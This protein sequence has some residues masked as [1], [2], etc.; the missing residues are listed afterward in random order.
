MKSGSLQAESRSSTWY[1][2][3]LANSSLNIKTYRRHFQTALLETQNLVTMLRN[4]HYWKLFFLCVCRISLRVF[5]ATHREIHVSLSVTERLTGNNQTH[6]KIHSGLSVV[7]KLQEKIMN[8]QGNKDFL[9]RFG[10]YS[11]ENSWTHRKIHI[12]LSI[13]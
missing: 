3:E 2:R 6:R 11:Q 10:K 4:I 12:F 9:C 5:S 13:L 7:W 1:I 8:K